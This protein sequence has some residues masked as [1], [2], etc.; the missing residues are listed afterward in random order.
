M[1]S[2]EKEYTQQ[3]EF[4]SHDTNE[5]TK[6]ILIMDDSPDITLTFKKILEGPRI[7]D[8]SGRRHQEAHITKGKK[9]TS[10]EVITYNDPFLA[11]S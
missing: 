6:R 11:L 5:V 4:S 10:F 3:E 2:R 7:D 8:R 1:N 9:K